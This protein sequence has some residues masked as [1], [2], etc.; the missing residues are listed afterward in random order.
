MNY[1]GCNYAFKMILN[2]IIVG[3]KNSL[4]KKLVKDFVNISIHTPSKFF[5]PFYKTK[6]PFFTFW[7]EKNR[8]L[9]WN[10]DVVCLCS[11]YNCKLYLRGM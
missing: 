5:S 3:K 11:S 4:Q 9:I 7:I 6:P 1:T 10:I 2:T 8:H